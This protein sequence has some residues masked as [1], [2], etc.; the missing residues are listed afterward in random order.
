MM[1]PIF[2]FANSEVWPF[3]FAPHDVGTYPK[4]NGQVYG[5][6]NGKF[7]HENQKP[8]EESGNMLIMYAAVSL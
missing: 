5:L 6:E 3:D 1:R 7:V 4:A 8:V 2:K